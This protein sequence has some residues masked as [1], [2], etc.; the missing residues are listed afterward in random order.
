ML[1]KKWRNAIVITGNL[2]SKLYKW[3]GEI[4][5]IFCLKK[6]NRLILASAWTAIKSLF[7]FI[8]IILIYPVGSFNNIDEMPHHLIKIFDI[9]L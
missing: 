8:G 7:I 5:Q 6:K 1:H 2:L 4:P 3:N 9:F